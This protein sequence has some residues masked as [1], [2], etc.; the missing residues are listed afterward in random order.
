MVEPFRYR[1]REILMDFAS[2]LALAVAL[3]IVVSGYFLFNDVPTLGNSG[4]RRR[5]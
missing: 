4:G 3:L 1:A 5:R 2:F